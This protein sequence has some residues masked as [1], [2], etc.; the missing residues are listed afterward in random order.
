MGPP[1]QSSQRSN[2]KER[3]IPSTQI[4]SKGSDG[5]EKCSVSVPVKAKCV[6]ALTERRYQGQEF[7]EAPLNTCVSYTQVQRKWNG[8]RAEENNFS[9]NV[10][11]TAVDEGTDHKMYALHRWQHESIREQ[12]YHTIGAVL[13]SAPSQQ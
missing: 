6:N 5:S 13:C 7:I 3:H 2:D 9:S 12:P 8:P 4:R 11:S 1:Q 10:L